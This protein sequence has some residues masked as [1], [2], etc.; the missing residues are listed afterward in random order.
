M[1]YFIS[2]K[3]LYSSPKMFVKC[4]IRYVIIRLWYRFQWKW[5]P[6]GCFVFPC[7]FPAGPEKGYF[8]T[9]KCISFTWNQSH[10]IVLVDLTEFPPIFQKV[11]CFPSRHQK[12]TSNLFRINVIGK[13]RFH[14][15]WPLE[16][17]M[18]IT[19]EKVSGASWKC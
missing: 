4:L 5:L 8:H 9:C 7:H 6:L 12:T 10:S 15:S 18:Y 14:N 16:G 19:M 2:I 1:V 13:L 3:V 17:A 11:Q